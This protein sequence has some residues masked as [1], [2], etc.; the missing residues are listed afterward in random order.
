MTGSVTSD[1]PVQ[2]RVCNGTLL[3]EQRPGKSEVSHKN[4]WKS[5]V[6]FQVS[7]QGLG[8]EAAGVCKE[9]FCVLHEELFKDMRKKMIDCWMNRTRKENQK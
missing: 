3:S 4:T 2:Q 8:R 6:K 5:R 7:Q 1:S 9:L